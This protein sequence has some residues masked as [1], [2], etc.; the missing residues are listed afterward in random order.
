MTSFDPSRSVLILVVEDDPLQRL[1]MIDL[2]EDAGFQAIEARDADQAIEILESRCDIRVVF[3]DIDMPGSMDG[4]K[5][6]A[7][8]RKRWPPI[9]IIVTSGGRKPVLEELPARATF[10]PKPLVPVDAINTLQ[11]FAS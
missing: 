4:L 5:L 9:E 10:L 11:S 1:G 7:A 8:V 3:T 6:A 2:V